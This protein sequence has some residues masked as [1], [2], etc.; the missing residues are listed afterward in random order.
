M[1][2]TSRRATFALVA[3]AALLILGL[4]FAVALPAQQAGANAGAVGSGSLQSI[5]VGQLVAPTALSGS[6]TSFS[7]IAT[8]PGNVSE[9]RR[10]YSGD[11]F[12]VADFATT[13]TLTAT[14]QFCATSD[15]DTCA[16]ATYQIPNDANTGVVNV[17]R[18][19]TLTA[20][21]AAYLT[22]PVA[23]QYW[24][25]RLVRDATVTPRVEVVL[26]NN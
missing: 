16:D 26:R 5:R 10:Y 14:L 20:D 24:R 6:G 3:L 1:H 21:G 8:T 11:I 12:V 2:T 17:A 25:V 19:V 15:T 23:G 7:T 9:V 22:A 4:T 18:S 13:G